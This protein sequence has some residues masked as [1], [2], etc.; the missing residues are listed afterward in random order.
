MRGEGEAAWRLLS[1]TPVAI[2]ARMSFANILCPVDFSEPSRRALHVAMSLARERRGAVTIL[3]VVDVQTPTSE[4][5]T[6]EPELYARLM[7]AAESALADWQ[8]D[9]TRVCPGVAV[10]IAISTGHTWERIVGFARD[11]KP[12]LVVMGTHGRTG[13]ANVPLGSVAERVTRYAPCSVLIVRD[14]VRQ[15]SLLRQT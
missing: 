15:T 5:P 8:A 7:A 6:L 3:H 2:T 9:A 13:A 1:G 11:R 12:D 4:I 10:T 14:D